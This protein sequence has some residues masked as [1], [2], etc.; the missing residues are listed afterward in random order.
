MMRHIGA[1]AAR[2]LRSAFTTPVAYV[3]LTV[4]AAQSGLFFFSALSD[5]RRTT[6]ALEQYGVFDEL[7]RM[8]LNQ[9][10]IIPWIAVFSVLFMF[11]IPLLTMRVFAEERANGTLELLFTS[12]VTAGELVLGKYL[13]SLGMLLALV[14][15][16]AIYPIGLFAY[17]DPPPELLPTVAGFLA[18]FLYGATLAALGCLTSSLTKS[19]ALAALIAFVIA[20]ALQMIDSVTRQSGGWIAEVARFASTGA[21]F[22][23][24]VTGRVYSEDLFYFVGVSAL[25]LFVARHSVESLRFR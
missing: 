2:E 25:L 15:I 10:V 23:N 17:G 7:A 22:E 14:A 13:A 11:A 16:S 8:N 3:I 21:H 24:G 6:A 18:L 1:I 19:Q 20:V 5:F 9:G 4:Y 12:P